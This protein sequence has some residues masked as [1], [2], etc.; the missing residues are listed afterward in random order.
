MKSVYYHFHQLEIEIGKAMMLTAVI[1][2]PLNLDHIKNINSAYKNII[3]GIHIFYFLLG[4]CKLKNPT[5][6]HNS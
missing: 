6:I 3:S 4:Y 5:E 2:N 1:N